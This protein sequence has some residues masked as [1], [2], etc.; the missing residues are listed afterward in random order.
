MKA[1]VVG[2]RILCR[3]GFGMLRPKISLFMIFIPLLLM[4]IIWIITLSQVSFEQERIVA[5]LLS[6][7][8]V[9]TLGIIIGMLL[10][11]EKIQAQFK[12]SEERLQIVFDSVQAG[13]SII[14]AET[15]EVFDVNQRVLTMV[16]AKREEIVGKT[17]HQFICPAE[18]GKCPITDLAQKIDASERILLTADGKHIPVIKTVVPIMLRGRKFLLESFIDI[19]ERKKAENELRFLSRHDALTGLRNRTYFEEELKS[20]SEDDV[21]SVALIVCDID[22]LKLVNDTLGHAAGDCL[23]M[24]TAEIVKF[25]ARGNTV[26]RIGGDEFAIIFRQ[27]EEEV[28]EGICEKIK[29]E[30]NQYNQENVGIS[31]SLSFGYSVQGKRKITIS[32]LFKEAD[33]NMYREKLH[34]S[35]SVRSDIVQTVMKML[36]VRDF[37]TEG[38]ADRVEDLLTGLGRALGLAE[39]RIG[40]IRL[41]AKFHDIGKVGIPDHIL[42]KPMALDNEERKYM[43]RHSEIGYRIAQSSTDLLPIADWILKHHEWWDGKGYPLGLAGEDIP[44]ECRILAIVDSYDAMTNDR[45]YRRAMSHQDAI[46]ELKRYAGLQFDPRLVDQFI[47][48]M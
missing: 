7:F 43:N 1:L 31:L 12:E 10:R 29:Q 38:H 14:D 28:V 23:L 6:G 25:V 33:D 13:I 18:K 39:K 41:L 42:F 19:G 5:Y 16:G 46:A 24:A 20:L 22:G 15:H 37:I 27:I 44:L 34:R 26:A 40:D 9:V 30:V 47:A 35:Q 11:Q 3:C 48:V 45:P 21:D 4:G 36:E 32:D 2:S 17:C 8:I